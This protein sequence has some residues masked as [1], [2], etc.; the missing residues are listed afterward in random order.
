VYVVA[1]TVPATGQAIATASALAKPMD[2]RVHVIAARPM[3][4]EWS[5]DQRSAPVQ[6]FAREIKCLIRA[7]TTP[8]NIVPCVCSRLID[9]T[10][11][12]PQGALVIIAGPSHRWWPTTEQR[13]AHDL[14][15][16]GHRVMFLHQYVG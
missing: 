13:L 1:T 15:G 5:L 7:V 12:L 9:V 2:A 14:N 6:A 16:L 8:I 11:L 3:P 10:L 4:T